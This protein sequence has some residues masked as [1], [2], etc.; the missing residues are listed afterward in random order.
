MAERKAVIIDGEYEVVPSD[1][2]VADLVGPE[3][4][5]ISTSSGEIFSRD[6]FR[7]LPVPAGFERQLQRVQKG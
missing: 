7:N 5:S 4:E 6:Q 3:V 1:A 2:R